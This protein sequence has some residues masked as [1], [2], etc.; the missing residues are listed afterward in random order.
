MYLKALDTYPKASF[1]YPKPL[2]KELDYGFSTFPYCRKNF[3]RPGRLFLFINCCDL[4]R[5]LKKLTLRGGSGPVR[6]QLQ[7]FL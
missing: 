3:F 5:V 4:C 7:C 1:I 6:D 2:N